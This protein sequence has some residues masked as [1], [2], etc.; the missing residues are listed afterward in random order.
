MNKLWTF[1]INTNILFPEN[2][3]YFVY[4]NLKIK[5][6][7]RNKEKKADNAIICYDA[8]NISDGEAYKIFAEY[9]NALAFCHQSFINFYPVIQTENNCDLS[10]V[11]Y[12][13]DVA[14]IYDCF[15]LVPSPCLISNVENNEQA[16]LIS[17]FN[18]AKSNQNYCFKLLFFWHS[19]V[20]PNKDE[21]SAIGFINSN[22]EKADNFYLNYIKNK[23]LFSKNGKI[24]STVGNYIKHGVRN[25]IAHIIRNDNKA[26]SLELENYEQIK[27]IN[28][29]NHI[30]EDISK[31]RIEEIYNVKPFAPMNVL[32]EFDPPCINKH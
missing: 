6:I 4:K 22:L 7:V 13:S 11:N 30:L 26:I 19:L 8:K 17:L 2:E 15:N 1:V 16:Q 3:Y 28:A 31:Y 18:Q 21:K 27:H 24:D 14:R 9:L 5:Y 29:L 10:K 32:Y 20:Y 25:S 12:G 23:P